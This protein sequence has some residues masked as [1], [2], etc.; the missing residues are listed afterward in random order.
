M[1]HRRVVR[2]DVV[3]F[4]HDFV[5]RGITHELLAQRAAIYDDAAAQELHAQP[6]P[7]AAQGD[8]E[9]HAEMHAVDAMHGVPSNPMVYRI[10]DDLS[11]DDVVLYSSRIFMNGLSSSSTFT[12]YSK[13]HHITETYQKINSSAPKPKGYWSYNGGKRMRAQLE[14]MA[15]LNGLDP[16][17]ADHWYHASPQMFLQHRV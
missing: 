17:N 10:R 4:K 16:L 12:F 2:G 13:S 11:W 1:L 7:R 15:K 9:T 5:S 14:A 8:A 3:T 6:Q